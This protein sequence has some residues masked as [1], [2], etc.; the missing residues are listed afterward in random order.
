MA[1]I[2]AGREGLDVDTDP[3]PR[4]VVAVFGSVMRV[5]ERMWSEGDDFSLSAMRE[6][7]ATYLEQVGPPLMGNWRTN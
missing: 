7:T 3:R 4:L 1:R 2:V 5:T 6:L